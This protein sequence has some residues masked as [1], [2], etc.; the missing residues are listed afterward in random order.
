MFLP[1][2]DLLSVSEM[3][4]SV[5][6]KLCRTTNAKQGPLRGSREVCFCLGRPGLQQYDRPSRPQGAWGQPCT[7]PAGVTQEAGWTW[8][9]LRLGPW[10][11]F[12]RV[13]AADVLMSFLFL[14]QNPAAEG[15]AQGPLQ[16]DGGQ[17]SAGA[18][19]G[20]SASPASP[21]AWSFLV[22][23]QPVPD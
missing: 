4:V 13:A 8:G 21:F 17:L 22:T 19:W 2:L 11:L 7:R 5:P 23:N 9:Q 12:L 14:R 20:G 1:A 10:F 16:T 3:C 15:S 6:E 18:V